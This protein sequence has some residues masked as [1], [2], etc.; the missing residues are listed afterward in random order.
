MEWLG[1]QRFEIYGDQR[2]L[3]GAFCRIEVMNNGHTLFYMSHEYLNSPRRDWMDID[4]LC[5]FPQVPNW[6]HKATILQA[7]GNANIQLG[8][9]CKTQCQTPTNDIP[10]AQNIRGI[11]ARHQ[12]GANHTLRHW[13]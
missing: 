12:S 9:F 7:M 8:L 1:L 3:Y 10:G 4:I 11:S 6:Q 13:H 2:G 5:A